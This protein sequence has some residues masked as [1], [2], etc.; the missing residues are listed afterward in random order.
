MQ[1]Y[2]NFIKLWGH[3]ELLN[4]LHSMC[5]WQGTLWKEITVALCHILWKEEPSLLV[6][7]ES[8]VLCINPKLPAAFHCLFYQ[9]NW[10]NKMFSDWVWRVMFVHHWTMI[11]K[12]W[13]NDTQ[14]AG[15]SL[16]LGRVCVGK[17]NYNGCKKVKKHIHVF[18]HY[19]F[20]CWKV[21]V[22]KCQNWPLDYSFWK[23][24]LKG[25]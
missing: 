14:S 17:T 21:L 23:M 19:D 12:W 3:S 1:T 20:V 15:F 4:G 24:L 8:G 16:Y 22:G 18:V 2:V 25:H 5:W 7:G 13:H 9:G 11:L 6:H 10:S